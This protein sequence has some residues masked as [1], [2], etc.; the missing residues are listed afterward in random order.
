RKHQIL[1]AYYTLEEL[2]HYQLLGV[3][4][5]AEKKTIKAAYYEVVNVFHPDRYFGKQLGGFKPKLE[6]VFARMT[7]AHEV[8]TRTTTRAEYDAYL[9]TQ[10]RTNQLDALLTNE[11]ALQLEV[12]RAQQLIEREAQDQTNQEAGPRQEMPSGTPRV[13]S[14]IRVVRQRLR[15]LSDPA[16]R[17][18]ALARKLRGSGTMPA[19]SIA[20]PDK[21]GLR[22]EVDSE[23]RQ[24]YQARLTAAEQNQVK[25]Y[26]EAALKAE[27]SNDPASAAGALRIAVQLDPDN[28][29]LGKR[30][31]TMQVQAAQVLANS[32]LQQA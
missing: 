14:P 7:E 21:D 4:P 1:N 26:V 17:R 15:K 18:K 2:T 25:H 28:E 31:E 11:Q 27:A 10:R 23:L 12:Q 30:L 13:P 32:Y 8:L 22:G 9:V 24:R 19:P 20:P 5:D 16:M 3:A 29:A 6:R